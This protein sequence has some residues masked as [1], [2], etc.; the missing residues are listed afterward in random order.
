[1]GLLLESALRLNGQLCRHGCGVSASNTDSGE[2]SSG[3]VV[4]GESWVVVWRLSVVG[5]FCVV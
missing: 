5:F 1:M 2:F 3:R 4:G